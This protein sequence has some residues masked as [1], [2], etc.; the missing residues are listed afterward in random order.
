MILAIQNQIGNTDDPVASRWVPFLFLLLSLAMVPWIIWLGL[1]LPS[2]QRSANYRD[3][4]VG[5]DVAEFVSLLG[6]AVTAMRA[7]RLLHEFALIASVLL[8][9]DAWFDVMNSAAGFAFE[10]ALADAILIEVPLAILCLWVSR[11]A[12]CVARCC[13]MLRNPTPAQKT[14]HGRLNNRRDHNG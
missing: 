3:A 1:H 13:Q 11:N 5:Y 4:W 9:V 10:T 12:A 2:H 14:N 8:T 6:V 7:S